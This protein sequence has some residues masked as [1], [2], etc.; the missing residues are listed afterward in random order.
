MHEQYITP[1]QLI[2]AAVQVVIEPA[3]RLLE[4]DQHTY[5]ARPCSTCRSI[6]AII[7][8]PFGCAK[9]YKAA[10][11]QEAGRVRAA[12]AARGIDYRNTSTKKH[13]ITIDVLP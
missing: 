8:R 3:L 10:I 12:Y 1:E 13:S 6:S 9:A 11:Q 7:G 4:A 2:Q 5:S